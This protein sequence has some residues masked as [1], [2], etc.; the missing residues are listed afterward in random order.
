MKSPRAHWNW[1]LVLPAVA[2]M[3]PGTY[4]KATPELFGFPFFYWYQMGWIVLTSVI[5]G[6]VYLATRNRA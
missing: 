5:T 1:L 3:F 6:L 2:L 4:A